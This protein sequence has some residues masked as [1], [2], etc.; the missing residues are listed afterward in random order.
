MAEVEAALEE[1]KAA[2]AAKRPKTRAMHERAAQV[3][4]GG[5]T[6]TV[7]FT[8]PFPLRVERASGSTITDID[9]HSYLD[10][11]GEYSAGIYGH[12]HP[13]ILDAAR[14][15]LDK[16]LNYGAHHEGEVKLAQLVTRRFNMDLVRFTNSGTEANM[17]ALAAARCFTGRSKI[18]PMSG[19]YHGG[20]LYFSH[21]ASPVNAPFDCVMG[22]FNDA[23][24]TL[25]R[26]AGNA[27]DLAAVIL[28]PML[29]GGGCIPAGRDFLA[30]LRGETHMRGIV[31]IFD[32]VMTS[33]LHP[34][35]LSA[36]LGIEP[37]LKTLGKYVGGG[38]SFGA[39]GGRADIMALF[40]PA[41]PAALP[42]AGTFNNNTL[43][44]NVGHVAMAD[45]YTP[46]A[47]EELNARG[48]R[49]REMLN[50]LFLSYQVK[51]KATGQ[52]S[53]IAIHPA[54]G[55]IRSPH[56][57]EHTDKRLRQL[58]FLDLLEQGFY[59]AERGFMAL[60]LMVTDAD[61]ARLVGAVEDYVN[62]RRD[63]L[64]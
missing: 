5:N 45:V 19:G 27:G 54:A 26:I 14:A 8:A 24:T 13:R 28:E 56:D 52:G 31:L 60:S 62:R 18:M 48:D 2:F 59:I 32:E 44:M 58:L 40:D 38:M 12:S 11:L 7:L 29:G 39:F 4:P 1:A 37:D 42:H 55:D 36:K 47:C 51:M 30:M 63:L 50:D 41:S 15:A 10:L 61:C 22:E 21:G 17:M 23:G 46:E 49:L 6:R 33:R 16:G 35:G 43:T 34:G 53:M 64:V 3:M 25:G 57:I 20:T 9:G